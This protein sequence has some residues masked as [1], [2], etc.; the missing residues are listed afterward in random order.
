MKQTQADV[1][2]TLFRIDR[3]KDGD[4]PTE[5]YDEATAYMGNRRRFSIKD[6]FE[7]CR[8]WHDMPP[9]LQK[10]LFEDRLGNVAER[11]DFFFNDYNNQMFA[12]QRV[13]HL[14]VTGME[15][16]LFGKGERIF[17]KGSPVNDFVFIYY[18]ACNLYGYYALNQEALR[19]K[20]VTLKKGSWFGDYQILLDIPS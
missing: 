12:P 15:S 6:S 5:M 1:E 10:K 14:M 20:V 3:L 17:A 9:Q 2:D 11:F 16:K 8:F 13:I 7:E 4:L 18:G 19:F